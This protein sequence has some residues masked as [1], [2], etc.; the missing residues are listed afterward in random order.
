MKTKLKSLLALALSVLIG[1]VWAANPTVVY[2]L[3]AGPTST[4]GWTTINKNGSYPA[5]LQEDTTYNSMYVT[6]TGAGNFFNT[7][8]APSRGFAEG[9]YLALNGTTYSSVL[10]EMANSLGLESIP[11]SVYSDNLTNGGTT[12]HIITVNGLDADKT[13][14]MYYIGGANKPSQ[15]V[16]GFTLKSNGYSGIPKVEYVCTSGN[17][18]H[19]TSTVTEY[20]SVP[21]T[22]AMR[23]AADGYLLV[24]VS[25][26]QPT[27]SGTIS[28]TL[29][30]ERANICALAIAEIDPLAAV[31]RDLKSTEEI[32]G[33]E[34]N[35]STGTV[36]GA[37]DNV[38]LNV[39]SETGS[40]LTLDV[41]ASVKDLTISGDCAVTFA[42]SGSL[43]AQNTILK[44]DTDISGIT[45]SLG[46]TTIAEGKTLTVGALNPATSIAGV[47]AVKITADSTWDNG[48]DSGIKNLYIDNCTLT[49]TY[50]SGGS[51]IASGRTIT[52]DG[53]SAVL[54]VNVGDGTGYSNGLD[55]LI[56]AKNGGKIL[57]GSRDTL[58]TAVELTGGTV[59]IAAE[60]GNNNRA[61]DLFNSNDTV[62]DFTVLAAEDATAE[63]PTV[64][65]ITPLGTGIH[66]AIHLRGGN[67]EFNVAEN[68]VL[69]ISGYLVDNA[70]GGSA[71][72]MK[73]TG[74]GLMTLCGSDASSC[75]KPIAVEGGTLKVI[76][77]ASLGTSAVTVA[78]GATIAGSGTI[79]GT[80]TLV[81]G[82]TVDATD[83]TLTVNGDVTLPSEGEVTVKVAE[84]AEAG[85]TVITCANAEAVAAALTGAPEGLRYVAENG[86]VKLAAATVTVTLPA[87]PENMVW[88]YDGQPVE[89]NAVTVNS[90]TSVT[91]T[92]KPAI[93]YIFSDN[94]TEKTFDLGEV[95]GDITGEID[96]EDIVAVKPE[97]KIGEK[98]YATFAS[99]LA[100]AADG[101][102]IV[103][104]KD[105]ICTEKPVFNNGGVVNVDVRDYVFVSTEQAR[106][107]NVASA[108]GA[109]PSN[110]IKFVSGFGWEV[111][112]PN[113]TEGVN[114]RVFP[115]LDAVIAYEPAQPNPARI[116]PYENIL[117]DKDVTLRK[118]GHGTSSTIC[119]DSGYEITWDLNGYTVMQESPTGNPL[120]V[121]IRGTLILEDSSESKSG[122]WIAGACGVT[123]STSSWYGNGGP[124]FYVLGDGRL[125]LNGG[126]VS[127]SRN[128]DA[129][130]DEIVNTGG[131][132]RIDGGELVVNDGV[133]LAV[134]DEYGI[135]AWG[136]EV[137]VNGGIF[138]IDPN[139][140][141][142]VYAVGYYE[143]VAVEINAPIEGELCVYG[144][145]SGFK[146]ASATV[147]VAGVKY[148]VGDGWVTPETGEGLMA[149]N[150]VV[151]EAV[152]ATVSTADSSEYYETLQAAFE[153]AATM[154]GPV[155]VALLKDV[156]SEAEAAPVV[157]IPE[158]FN[159]TLDLGGKT[160][161]SRIE[162]S[163]AMVA[164][165]V[166]NGKILHRTGSA[167]AIDIKVGGLL[168]LDDVYLETSYHGVR[169]RRNAKG[170]INSGD[171]RLVDTSASTYN[172]LYL[173]D[174]PASGDPA[175][176]VVN[177]GDFYARNVSS[178]PYVMIRA[179]IGEVAINDGVFHAYLP[180]TTSQTWCIASETGRPIYI[181]GG[182]FS[183]F[184]VE[185]MF[186]AGNAASVKEVYYK[187]GK[188]SFD[189]VADATS[190][191][192]L[193]QM[194]AGY[195]AVMLEGD[196]FYTVVEKPA[197]EPSGSIEV[198]AADAAAAAN[199]VE[200]LI[201][202][203]VSGVD[204]ATYATY[205]TK[206]AEAVEGTTDKW[207]VT[208]ALNPEVVTPKITA[209][210][211]DENGVTIT[212]E[213]KLPGLYY[214]VRSA[215]TVDKVD[216]DEATVTTELNAPATG[217]AAFY[218]VLVDFAP[219]PTTPAE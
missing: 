181:N 182:D 195:H 118:Y 11:A 51:G 163:K 144:N 42:G 110:N 53:D 13:Y 23:A 186:K 98:S 30:G 204:A 89:N 103:L 95:T 167:A 52:V 137:V 120:E 158:G 99:A 58:K 71:V 130:G 91:V 18:S 166:K 150:G 43:S 218:R 7:Y 170:V 105:V 146:G 147:N 188:F 161:Y 76:A 82:S 149:V 26:I 190:S 178:G 8:L 128:F 175:S 61:I 33:A 184:S 145:V 153:A 139:V 63:N 44:A 10:E 1:Q 16:A 104:E 187:G 122:K 168:T 75:T 9:S 164:L 202:E 35:W 114:F 205:F 107:R 65:Y 171:Y 212:L 62:A 152:E 55:S 112:S 132:I 69:E 45:A 80:L 41:E 111:Y 106:V 27:T 60:A 40:K 177:G 17:S 72:S 73:K 154:T 142:P 78:D 217:D 56:A 138:D 125:V 50:V 209:I 81:A 211:F 148:A 127:I 156:G 174:A 57:F 135:M 215:A 219:I 83:G 208:A 203:G 126:T 183:E 6:S 116:Y 54:F 179:L 102:T 210:S 159:G 19:N 22:T 90:G 96:I 108:D 93:D 192:H 199:K 214:A 151:T 68:A 176:L 193:G 79:G 185:R 206:N 46:A 3:D 87:A 97:V 124:A 29:N 131:L 24:R 70:G 207:T 201:P 37:D 140:S 141:K 31:T 115:T 32:W 36:P 162:A 194:V 155:T 169:L 85:D 196:D 200:I 28:F 88:F 86:A 34:G 119:V 213:N 74:V 189:P 100:A 39:I 15:T 2:L 121:S 216:T 133:T 64:S 198:S 5:F 20:T 143:D 136:G 173:S 94:T 21:V 92:L 157:S 191:L 113:T 101:D 117:Q 172:L 180:G 47:G 59:E 197:I 84:T 134:E 48:R 160:L 66:R 67:V 123:D 165:T 25:Y 109:V 77:P 38:K 129:N 14:V 4:E 49:S 12:G